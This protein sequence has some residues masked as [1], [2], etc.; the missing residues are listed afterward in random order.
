MYKI[1]SNQNEPSNYYGEDFYFS[2]IKGSYKSAIFFVRT[3][4]SIYKPKSV[5]DLGCGRG[6]WLKAFIENGAEKVVGIDGS[7]NS[8]ANMIDPKI[9][10]YQADLNQRIE[11]TH[12]IKYDL[13]ISLEVAEH[14]DES[15]ANIFIK[16]LTNFSDLVMFGS[17]FT[18]Q[19][20]TNHI[21]EQPHTYWA[22]IFMSY[23]Y[24]P[25]DIFR[26]VLWGNNEIEF[27]YQQNTFLYIRKDSS[28]ANIFAKAGHF[29]IKN[30]NFMDCIHPSL[31]NLKLRRKSFIKALLPKQIIAFIRKSYG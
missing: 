15:S 1:K 2:Q 31:Y 24:L 19:G 20:G 8:Q 16:S 27:W 30:I 21:N 3:L 23:N 7:W 11:K 25:Y 5:V 26:P 4:L 28:I 14:L 9:E 12:D 29:P 13:S 18:A 10:F 6:A 17:A 22:K